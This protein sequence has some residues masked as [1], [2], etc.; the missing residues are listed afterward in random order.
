MHA[1]KVHEKKKPFNI[2]SVHEEKKLFK[3]RI[4]DKAFA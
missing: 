1:A 3:C 2:E 4:C